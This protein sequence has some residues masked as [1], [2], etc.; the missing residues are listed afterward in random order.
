MKSQFDLGNTPGV[1]DA[2][3]AIATDGSTFL[4]VWERIIPG[5]AS[6]PAAPTWT[7]DIMV[8]RFTHDGTAIGTAAQLDR[9]I[10]NV[11][12]NN[13]GG[14]G[15]L[16]VTW[17]G[18]QYRV[19]VKTPQDGDILVRDVSVEADGSLAFTGYANPLIGGL[20]VGPYG[21]GTL[22][23][24]GVRS[25][26]IAYDPIGNR[27]LLVYIDSRGFMYGKIYNGVETT[28]ASAQRLSTNALIPSVSFNPLTGG[29]LVSGESGTRLNV[30]SLDSALQP[31][32]TAKQLVSD[33]MAGSALACP[34]WTA[35]PVLD[36][37]FEELPGTTAY[38]DSSSFAH[39][40][41]STTLPAAAYPGAATLDS[42]G[43]TIAIGTP[44]S[45]FAARFDGVDDNLRADVL[46]AK[47]FSVDL[48]FRSTDDA[49]LLA[50]QQGYWTLSLV[51]G[52]PIFQ[53]DGKQIG[54]PIANDGSWHNVV[55]THSGSEGQ[56]RLY[57][58][59]ALV[60]SDTRPT[61]TYEGRGLYIGGDPARPANTYH[62][63]LDNVKLYAT[64]LSAETVTA[65]YNGNQS[66]YCVAAVVNKSVDTYPW[67]TLAF[68]TPDPRGGAIT[69]DGELTLSVNVE[70]PT[71]QLL[72][73]EN[74]AVVAGQRTLI[75]GGE[76]T[77]P[78][79][80]SGVAKVEVSITGNGYNGEWLAATGADSWAF[81]LNVTNGNYSIRTRAPT[82]SAMTRFLARP[83]RCR[84]RYAAEY[85]AQSAGNRPGQTG[86]HC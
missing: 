75:I 66:A 12:Q 84:S 83:S 36:L 26:D 37:R 31:Q 79:G 1:Q 49:G 50:G 6:T 11:S 30:V 68:P 40:V 38:A 51:N 17:I 25:Y 64:V 34:A 22:Q 44:P 53:I 86:P 32:G 72:G 15:E 61:T 2:N 18:E 73:Y 59:G 60:S 76:A 39:G 9:I 82:R 78:N 85:H 67:S 27:S 41:T 19:L 28:P 20:E 21:N 74:N 55:I 46:V 70:K 14:V 63:L 65:N 47:N 54:G 56:L 42:E 57:I 62:G 5:S 29:W 16:A 80:G 7:H 45:D 52:R 23:Q 8:Q 4:V 33:A 13:P 71:S 69:A 81:A 43:A 3:P 77:D 48:W 35:L 10:A 58:D 24:T